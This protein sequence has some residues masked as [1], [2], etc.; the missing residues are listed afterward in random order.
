[1]LLSYNIRTVTCSMSCNHGLAKETKQTLRP[2]INIQDGGTE[3]PAGRHQNNHVS[4]G[5]VAQRQNLHIYNARSISKLTRRIS[6]FMIQLTSSRNNR[7]KYAGRLDASVAT[8]SLCLMGLE[9]SEERDCMQTDCIGS[10]TGSRQFCED[11][12]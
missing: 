6:S 3:V 8:S 5:H 7:M 2:T 10:R 4:I 11:K 1:M 9:M 12:T